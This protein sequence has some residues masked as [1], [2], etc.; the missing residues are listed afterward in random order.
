M[1]T[2]PVTFDDL[3]GS[4]LAVPPLCRGADLSLNWTA[5]RDL[6]AHLEAGGVGT[7]MYGGNANF[8]NLP[9]TDFEALLERL[10]ELAGAETWI[11]PS[12]G[13]DYGRLMDQAAILRRFDYPTAMVLPLAFPATPA[14][15]EAGIRRF[16]E[17]VGKPAILYVKFE[18]YLDVAG[19]ARLVDDGLVAAIKYAVVRQD[20]SEDP[21]LAALCGAIDRR[22][23]VS[24]IGERPVIDHFRGF[25]LTSFT[26]GSVCVAPAASTAIL[27]ALQAGDDGRAARLREAFLPLEDL[28][29]GIS[30]MRV[31]HEAV[32]LAGIA[33]SGPVLPLLSN[34]ED[35]DRP[36]VEGAAKALL[37]FDQALVA[38]A[39]EPIAV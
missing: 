17:A 12:C 2:T 14:G 16:V 39:A 7:L 10:P 5:N 15:A 13:P 38:G 24:G 19:I 11:I 8:Y 32:R 23:I 25:G 31:L 35:K 20:P 28:R 34:I 9:L 30:P 4:V 36:A 21:F 3:T 26:S 22:M 33:D 6:I 1:K 27:H 37:A 29:D 18:G